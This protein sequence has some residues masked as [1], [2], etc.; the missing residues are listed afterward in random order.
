MSTMINL[1]RSNA[2][3]EPLKNIIKNGPAFAKTMK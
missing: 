3:N 2:P 1:M